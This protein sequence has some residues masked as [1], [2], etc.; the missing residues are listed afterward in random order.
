MQSKA[1]D[2]DSYMKEVKQERQEALAR[3][4]ELCQ[5]TL[6]GYEESM[7]YGMP[8]YKKDGVVEVAFASQKQ[9]ISFYV[10]KEAVLNKHRH[11]LE[12]LNLGKGCIRYSKPEKIDFDVVEQ[13]LTESYISDSEIC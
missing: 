3:L 2:V 8:S 12:G 6:V 7:D 10:L 5:Q 1:K 13:L 9:Y 4:R 11:L